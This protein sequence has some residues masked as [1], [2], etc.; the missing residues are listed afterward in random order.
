LWDWIASESF[1]HDLQHIKDVKR[2]FLS[3]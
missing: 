2:P 3:R 1:R